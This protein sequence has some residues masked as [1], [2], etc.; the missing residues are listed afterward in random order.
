MGY[1]TR[2]KL[3][4]LDGDANTPT[5][6][7]DYLVKKG[8]IDEDF[9]FEADSNGRQGLEFVNKWY[10]HDADMLLLSQKIPTVELRLEG[11]GG[12]QGDVWESRFLNGQIKH[13]RPRI[14][15]PTEEDIA[16]MPWDNRLAR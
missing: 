7:W 11:E 2:F 4:F 9:A 14:V 5:T 13:L 1:Q 3:S 10:E 6:V 15:W 12:S 8:L 16:A